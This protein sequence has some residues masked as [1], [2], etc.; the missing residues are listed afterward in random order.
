MDNLICTDTPELFNLPRATMLMSTNHLL[1]LSVDQWVLNAFV[2]NQS[3]ELAGAPLT[4]AALLVISQWILHL[5]LKLAIMRVSI[6]RT[7]CLQLRRLPIA[8][9]A[10]LARCFGLM[11][12]AFR[13]LLLLQ[14]HLA[15][16]LRTFNRLKLA[17]V[18]FSSQLT[19]LKLVFEGDVRLSHYYLFWLF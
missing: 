5:R 11:V 7:G 3:V 10:Q 15:L 16:T 13:D 1:S 12:S 19:H 18:S 8:N 2:F 9:H 4:E 14:V 6:Y 17:S